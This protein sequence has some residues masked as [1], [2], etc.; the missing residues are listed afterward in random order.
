MFEEEKLSN[1]SS[2]EDT[3]LQTAPYNQILKCIYTLKNGEKSRAGFPEA[4]RHVPQIGLGDFRLSSNLKKGRHA[5]V[6][7]DHHS[8]V[9][10]WY[11]TC[12]ELKYVILTL[13]LRVS[14]ICCLT[15][16]WVRSLDT[17]NYDNSAVKCYLD[18]IQLCILRKYWCHY[19][20]F[21]LITGTEKMVFK[22][23][24]KAFIQIYCEWHY[25][26]L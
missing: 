26:F 25:S 16:R 8:C 5:V 17:D 18:Y 13:S 12:C 9:C 19:M 6:D 21:I 10:K 24:L 15:S 4:S 22:Y 20:P 23:S 14:K 2:H 11:F 7:S 3:Q 1:I